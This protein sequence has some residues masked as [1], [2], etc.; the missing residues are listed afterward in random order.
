MRQTLDQNKVVLER[1]YGKTDYFS[2]INPKRQLYI[3]HSVSHPN[4]RQVI[5]DW[6]KS[7]YRKGAA[8]VVAGKP[9]ENETSY[10]DGMIFSAFSSKYWALHLGVHNEKNEIPKR[11]KNKTHT[12][13]LEKYS[14]AVSICNAGEVTWESGKFYS[15]FRTVVPDT[16]VI[17][18]VDGYRGK[19]FFHKYTK[20][21]VESLRQLL[22]FLC[23]KYDIPANYQP[24]M[25]ELSENA[26]LGRFGIFTLAS[27]RTDKVRC[28]PQ[29]DL[30][31]MLM[32]LHK[33]AVM[34]EDQAK[35]QAVGEETA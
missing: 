28:H 21:Q 18:Y 29:P 35:Q 7:S 34:P 3:H 32:D 33:D 14:I 20:A 2:E 8:F 22:V 16:E 4:P 6:R 13:F 5:K 12:R 27:V 23:N 31:E 11:Y 15:A 25:W 19:R 9:Y 10:E 30:V 26:L 24:D 17:E 1:M